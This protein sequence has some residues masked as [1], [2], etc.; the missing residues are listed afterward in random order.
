MLELDILN[1]SFHP[2]VILR[3]ANFFDLEFIQE[4]SHAEMDN[5]YPGNWKSWFKD[6]EMYILSNHNRI[7]VVEVQKTPA[8]YLW[9]NEEENS[10]WITAIVLQEEYQRRNIGQK[11]MHYLIKESRNEGKEFIELGVQ[12][13]NENALRFYFKLGFEKFDHIRYANTDL[14]RLKL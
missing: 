3:R 12:H 1:L 13:N 2:L 4:V 6:I 8:G 9:I 11:I 10:L 5:I 7:F 14:I